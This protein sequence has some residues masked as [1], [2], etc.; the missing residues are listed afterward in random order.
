MSNEIE[1]AAGGHISPF[2]Q[3]RRTN[4]AG[5][6]FWS[7]RDFAGVLGYGDYR[8]FEAVI[9]KAKR[10]CPKT[11]RVTHN[12]ET[13]MVTDN[14]VRRLWMLLQKGHTLQQAADKTSMDPK[15]ARKYR[16]LK[17]LPSQC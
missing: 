15:T 8:N 6:E 3:I 12:R 16:D 11:T 2:E 17:L 4:D 5:A 14:Q 7:S 10:L 9:E 13:Q 1:R